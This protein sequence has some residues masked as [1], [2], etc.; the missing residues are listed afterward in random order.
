[1]AE[2]A[3]PGLTSGAAPVGRFQSADTKLTVAEVPQR[4]GNDLPAVD[5]TPASDALAGQLARRVIVAER[6]RGVQPEGEEPRVSAGMSVA[7]QRRDGT[8]EAWNRSRIPVGEQIGERVEERGP[9]R[10]A[11]PCPRASSSVRPERRHSATPS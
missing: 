2:E 7:V 5:S 9:Q 11:R 3:L 4:L 6:E 10:W 1:M 8:P